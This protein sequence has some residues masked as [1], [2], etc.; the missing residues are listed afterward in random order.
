MLTFLTGTYF[1]AKKK[2]ISEKICSLLNDG[3]RVFLVV[4]EQAGFDRD[5]DFLFTYGEMLRHKLVITSF[6]HLG[7]DFLEE[8]GFRVKPEA[9]EAARNV[10][11]SI[12][13]SECAQE[14]EIFS[15]YSGKISLVSQL[16]SE[17][18]EIKQA[19]LSFEE[20]NKSALLLPHGKL[21]KKMTELSLIFSVYEALVGERFSERSNSMA[22]MT[23]FLKNHKVFIGA[24]VFFDDF[25][26]FTGAQI[27]LMTEIIS[28][29]KESFVSVYAPDSL[30][31]YDSEAFR[32]AVRNC[33]KLRSSVGGHGITVVEEKIPSSHPDMAIAAL[34]DSLF[35]VQ[36]EKYEEKTENVKIITAEDKYSECDTV[37]LEIKKLLQ[38]KN[39]RCRDICITE[40]DAG[41][42][43]SMISSLKK[44]GI[45]VFEDKR[46]PLFEYP[47]IKAVLCAVNI[48]VYGFS[49]D[50]I[51]S[52]IKTGVVGIDSV[53]CA[54]L[55]NYV[56]IWGIDKG[57]WLHTFTGHPDGF[58][59]EKCEESDGRLA[60]INALREKIIT[61]VLNLKRKL[62]AESSE[63]SC[64]AVYEFMTEINAA[65]NFLSYARFLYE[66]KNESGAV[67]CSQVWDTLIRSLDALYDAAG[68]SR[69]SPMRFYELL[70]IILSSQDIGRIPAGIDQIIIGSA[71]RMRHLEPRAVFVLGC[72][73][74]V[75]PA[76]VQMNGV[77]SPAERRILC[78]NKFPLENISE[79]IYAEE[80]MIAYS[81]L[82]LP[83]EKLYACYSRTVSGGRQN[84]RSEIIT[85]ICSILPLVDV[86]D[87]REISS[88]ERI[89]SA[90]T[91]FEECAAVYSENTVYSASL[92]KY[93]EK[94]VFGDKFEAVKI[95]ADNLP[96]EIKDLSVASGLFGKDM[97][98]SPS[99]AE[100]YHSC[101]FRYF[102]Q[103]GLKLSKPRPADLDARINGL[104]IHELMENILKPEHNIN[105]IEISDIRLKEHIDVF[106]EKFIDSMMGGR[107]D[108]GLL[109]NR[110]LDKAKNTAFE[111]L[112]RI[113]AEF[114]L[115]RFET[116][117]VELNISYKGDVK[118]YTLKLSDGG[119]ITI[120]GMV[121][122]VDIMKEDNKAYLRV[123]DYK[124]GGKD[125][126]LS[127][128]FD[129]LNMQML[130][131][132]MCLWDNG[133]ELF[134][135]V[136]P[137][138]ILYVPANVSGGQLPRNATAQEIE[139][140]KIRNGRMN[141]MI[142]EDENVLDGMEKG[143]NGYF[144]NASIDEKG[145]MKGTFLSV[146]GFMRLHKKIDEIL[147]NMGQALHNGKI[148]ALP[149]IDNS[150]YSKTCEYCDYKDICRRTENDPSREPMGLSH[151]DA[152]EKLKGDESDG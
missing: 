145:R 66:Q 89:G 45:P 132:L 50:N 3:E 22:D 141:G 19:G 24:Y 149:V 106:A 135:D 59:V 103:Y 109:L 56:Y 85:E 104:L 125:F 122:R 15:R 63:K 39:Y 140:Q 138:G 107:G 99:R 53:S 126:R 110:N 42:A 151:K 133:K 67:E 71:G 142:L 143:C 34:S 101:A 98:L 144:I 139:A 73:E 96:A 54:E 88:E 120:G 36:K 91:A 37:A 57:E 92:K 51:F 95:A 12:A 84:E 30:N 46:I 136:V 33:R 76:S 65:E 129:G 137:A 16:L 1:S 111:I 2:F 23:E 102:C 74:G 81:I 83:T 18:D 97:Y 6:S 80:L 9:D 87:D 116:A 10:L 131:Y 69:M 112:R 5:R 118:P 148:A 147:T 68:N 38:E 146:D 48:A 43:R 78:K 93:V 121:D 108:K 25:R 127:D 60:Q 94:S 90:E 14:L 117:A 8:N 26:G 105:L 35:C 113:R 150:H 124:T 21:R 32:H 134:G 123:V 4:P 58:G 114:S 86:I 64:R 62:E 77:F 82:T 119:S 130:I 79:N 128:V 29:A 17:Y 41:Y 52:Y 11:M 47:V 27:K 75:F 70:R 72:N 55:E 28:Q 61:P 31:S 115:S 7:R 13:V 40:R 44:Y 49:T 20:M 100:V 152:V